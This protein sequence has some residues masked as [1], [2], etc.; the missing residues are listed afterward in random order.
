[1]SRRKEQKFRHD[2]LCVS[3]DKFGGGGGGVWG[4]RAGTDPLL[5][6]SLAL[7]E[8]LN[9]T[10]YPQGEKAGNSTPYWRATAHLRGAVP[11]H[12]L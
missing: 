8:K 3:W 7:T 6:L 10:V 9:H 5:A 2:S 11:K 1:M 4:G 12:D